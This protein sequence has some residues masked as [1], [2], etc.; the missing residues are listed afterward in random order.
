MVHYAGWYGTKLYL[1]TDKNFT[2]FH[3]QVA[4]FFIFDVSDCSFFRNDRMFRQTRKWP[5]GLYLIEILY[6]QIEMGSYVQVKTNNLGQGNF[7]NKLVEL[8]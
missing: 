1:L 6:S 5:I 4:T 7:E 8:P 3:N 2:N